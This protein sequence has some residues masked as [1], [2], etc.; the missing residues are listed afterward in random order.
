MGG[1]VSFLSVFALVK[2]KVPLIGG[3]GGGG[4]RSLEEKLSVF[5]AT[6]KSNITIKYVS[7]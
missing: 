2:E 4:G 5:K 1:N 7:D 3:V 6:Q